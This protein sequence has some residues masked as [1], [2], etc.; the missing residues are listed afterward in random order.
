MSSDPDVKSD[1]V[2]KTSGDDSNDYDRKTEPS[3]DADKLRR[4]LNAKLANPLAGYTHQELAEK[5][6]SYC[7]SKEIGDEEDVRAFRLGAILAQNPEGYAEVDGLSEE[8]Q[9]ICGEEVT[10]RWSQPKLLYLVIV[11]CSTCAAV[12]GMGKYRPIVGLKSGLS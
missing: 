1:A 12:Q 11:L 2:R 4:N 9:R 7:R 10:K 6:E 5:G 8:E 3:L